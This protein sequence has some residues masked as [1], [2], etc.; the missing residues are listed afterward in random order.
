MKNTEREKVGS[1]K[2]LRTCYECRGSAEGRR[3]NYPYAACGL[4][5][6]VLT[7]VVVY[8]CSLCGAES[9]D[10]PNMDGLHHTIA[11]S[12]LCKPRLLSGDEIRFLRKVAGFTATGLAKS[13]SVTKHAVSRWENGARVGPASDKAIRSTCGLS[14]IADIVNQRAGA[15]NPND[16]LRTVQTLQGFFVRFDPQSVLAEVRNEAGDAEKLMIDP[17][18]NSFQYL[19]TFVQPS[20]QTTAVQ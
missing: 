11:L 4:K 9:V 20:S 12:V 5:N 13:L 18:L 15:V 16:V 3:E 1:G 19:P 7:G 14:I 17:S 8:R 6:V 2:L 10:I